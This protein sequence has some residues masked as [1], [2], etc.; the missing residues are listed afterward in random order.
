[1][2]LM[3][4]FRAVFARPRVVLPIIHVASREQALR[5]AAVAQAGG[6]DGV[7]LISHGAV[8]DEELL[9][10]Y[11]AVRESMPGL[12]AGVNC[13]S[14][15]PE[16]LFA[17]LPPGTQGVWTDNAL[18]DES[19]DEQPAAAAVRQSQERHGWQGLYFGGV[20][21]KYQRHVRDLAAAARRAVPW[22]DVVTTSGPGTGQA[23]PPAKVRAMKEAIGDAPLALAS[24]VTPENVNDYL[25]WVDAFLVST[26][27]SYDFEELDPARLADLVRVVRDWR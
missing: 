26:G 4:R 5:N 12:W 8:V 25:P 10:I 27:I 2:T 18:I 16:P 1:M 3:S 23:A 11:A 7:F 22:M 14:W 21:F 9:R 13:L 24:G 6:A 15:A 20:A 19:S 17:R